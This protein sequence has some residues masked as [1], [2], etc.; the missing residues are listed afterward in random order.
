MRIERLLSW[1]WSG[2]VPNRQLD[3]FQLAMP[4]LEPRVFRAGIDL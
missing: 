4:A 1:E 2:I 3:A